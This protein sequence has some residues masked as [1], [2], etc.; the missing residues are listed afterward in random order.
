V[1]GGKIMNEASFLMIRKIGPTTHSLRPTKNGWMNIL[2]DQG[3]EAKEVARL[4]NDFLQKII[5]TQSIVK[6]EATFEPTYSTTHCQLAL[7]II[8]AHPKAKQAEIMEELE[9]IN[10]ELANEIYANM[11]ISG[12][13]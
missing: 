13:W 6:N 4:T 8:K 7:K 5:Q 3:L 2:T 11:P 1:S 12:M 9:K 10:P